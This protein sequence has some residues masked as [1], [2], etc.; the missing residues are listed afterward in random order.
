MFDVLLGIDGSDDFDVQL[1]NRVKFSLGT[2]QE[3]T[4]ISPPGAGI[5]HHRCIA[6][7]GDAAAARTCP[8]F[9]TAC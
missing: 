7:G 4:A 3:C 8:G 9:Q 6:G 5:G 1:A 2:A